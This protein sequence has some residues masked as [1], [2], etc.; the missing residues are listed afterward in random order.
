MEKK[1]MPKIMVVTNRQ[2][3]QENFL[4]RI[5]KLAKTQ[6]SSII[7]REKDLPEE[8]YEVLAKEVLMICRRYKKEC[9]LHSFPDVA[10]KLGEKSI[11]LPL[12]KAAGYKKLHY[13]NRVGVSVHSVEEAKQAKDLGAAY[14]TAGHVFT[15]DCKPD[16]S[17]R[18]LSFLQNVCG[19]IPIPVFAIGGVNE[20]NLDSVLNAGADGICLMSSMMRC[21]DPPAYVDRLCFIA[22]RSAR[23]EIIKEK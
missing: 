3:C 22:E 11:H 14:V 19:A 16:L 4:V 13:F 9:I 23:K 10:L 12:W 8:K 21:S 6:I 5:E 15:T 2:I 1:P 18:G 7:L 20:N 17:P